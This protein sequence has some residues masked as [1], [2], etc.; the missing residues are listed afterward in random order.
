MTFSGSPGRESG[1]SCQPGITKTLDSSSM[2]YFFSPTSKPPSIP[3]VHQQQEWIS[4]HCPTATMTNHNI[5][6]DMPFTNSTKAH[7]AKNST[8][9]LVDQTGELWI[10]GRMNQY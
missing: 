9:R 1:N 3:A 10:N 5:F 4:V 8:P 2:S 7:I 6:M